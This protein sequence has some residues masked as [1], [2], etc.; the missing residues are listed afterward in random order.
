MSKPSFATASGTWRCHIGSLQLHTVNAEGDECIWCGPNHLAW[1]PGHWVPVEGGS[2][3]SAT[4]P[5]DFQS[6]EGTS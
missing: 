3:W 5:Y 4:E 1:K 2:A 6:E